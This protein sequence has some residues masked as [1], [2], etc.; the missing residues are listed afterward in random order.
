MA[1]RATRSKA[2]TTLQKVVVL[3]TDK[4][5]LL[6]STLESILSSMTACYKVNNAY[7]QSG[8]ALNDALAADEDDESQTENSRTGG[9]E[10]V[11]GFSAALDSVQAATRVL[12]EVA[13]PFQAR[14]S[15]ALVSASSR[16]YT[17]LD[18]MYGLIRDMDWPIGRSSVTGC[19]T[20][21]N[22]VNTP[23]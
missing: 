20:R 23:V 1:R 8:S 21:R 6:R 4:L 14:D 18:T 17:S 2:A 3:D 9:K 11:R 16:L 19:F 5:T 22:R 7:V 10:T 13:Y 15:Q 12:L